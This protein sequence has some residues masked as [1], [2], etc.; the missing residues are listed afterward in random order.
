MGFRN[1]L[2]SIS[3]D[4]VTPGVITGSTL[5]TA[6]TGKRVEVQAAGA[7]GSVLF[8]AGFTG[9]T[10]A[11]IDATTLGG[12]IPAQL[13]AI[14]GDGSMAGTQPHINLLSENAPAGGYQTRIDLDADVIWVNGM[15][16]TDLAAPWTTWVPSIT[17]PGTVNLGASPTDAGRYKRSGR[18]IHG[19]GEIT[20]GAGASFGTGDFHFPL[21]VTPLVQFV[22]IGTAWLVSAAGVYNVGMVELVGGDAVIRSHGASLPVNYATPWTWQSGC[23]I[24]IQFTYEAQ[25]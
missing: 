17:G 8:Y 4:Q 5:R 21:P 19:H 20:L 12:A 3:G 23:S 24:Y 22:L 2:T 25:S 11:S 15:N 14:K 13:L 9:E 1:P 18:Q 6:A 16:L 10:A 7:V